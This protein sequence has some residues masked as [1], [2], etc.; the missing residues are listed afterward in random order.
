M[1]FLRGK[2]CRAFHAPFD[3]LLPDGEESD[4]EVDTVVRPDILVI[5]D[6]SKITPRGARGAPDFAI[7][8][9]SPR[10]AKKDYGV[11]LELYQRH[12]VREYWI[13]DPDAK[14]IHA[15]TLGD[16]GVYGEEAIFEEGQS[17]PSATLEGFSIDTKGLFADLF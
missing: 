12:R 10:T 4:D 14:A 17:L 8:I 13:V 6:R 15:W 3:L 9:L 7:E 5:C 1:F 16:G 11:K 2:P